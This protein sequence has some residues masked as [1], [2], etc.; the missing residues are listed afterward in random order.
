MAGPLPLEGVRVADLTRY[1]AGPHCTGL[2]AH[3]GAEVIKV[4][5]TLGAGLRRQRFP[6][7]TPVPAEDPR[8]R[9]YNRVSN[10]DQVNVNKLSIALDI[11]SPQG[12]EVLLRLIRVSDVVVNNYSAEMMPKLGLDYETLRGAR[13]DIIAC[14]IPAFGTT[15]PWDRYLGYGVC[16]EPLA[17]YFSVTGYPGDIPARSGVDHFDPMTGTHAAA[18]ILTALVYRQRTGRGQFLDISH[19]ESGVEFMGQF[20]MD[21]FMNE[22]IATRQGNRHPAM[23][24][25]NA[26]PCLGEDRWVAIAVGPQ[27]EWQRLVEV[28][29]HPAWAEEERFSTPQARWQHQEELDRLIGAWTEGQE[30]REVMEKLQA[31]GVAAGAVL[32]VADLDRDPHLQAR[33]LFQ[34]MDH[35]EAGR[36]GLMTEPWR[37]ASSPRRLRRPAPTYGQDNDYVFSHLLGMGEEEIAQLA[38]AGVIARQLP[39]R[40]G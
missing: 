35:P 8:A 13:P 2:L 26:Y 7:R 40:D 27:E 9:T 6:Q 12:R 22:R 18:A 19:L 1:W 37:L 31:V 15:G 11:T 17:G 28:M 23:A 30:A 24:P 34:E 16:L 32:S 5:A 10:F 14:S 29:G 21:Y 36:H 39:G 25:H 38:R 3:L 33:G 4:E 20:L